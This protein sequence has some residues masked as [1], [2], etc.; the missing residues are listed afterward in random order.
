MSLPYLTAALIPSS[1][2]WLPKPGSWMVMLRRIFAL[3]L[4][5]TMLWLLFVLSNQINI[6]S[7]LIFAGGL[8]LLRMLLAKQLSL[9]VKGTL[10]AGVIIISFYLPLSLDHEIEE[11]KVLVSS[12]W[13]EF[14]EDKLN[15]S[16]ESGQIVFIDFTAEWCITCKINKFLVLDDAALILDLKKRGVILMRADLTGLKTS[17]DK[18]KRIKFTAFLEK[19]KRYGIPFNAVFSP[20]Y[21]KGIQLPTLLSKGD[22]ASAIAKSIR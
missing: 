3:I 22:I 18:E 5:S 10:L 8:L 15:S 16:I 19:N 1:L 20:G 21:P 17:I 14:D 6:R 11:N 13:E 7:V 2:N 12:L 4:I 9:P